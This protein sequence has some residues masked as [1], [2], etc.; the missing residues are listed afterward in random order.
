MA[1]F[2]SKSEVF[3]TQSIFRL[4][5]DALSKPGRLV[6]VPAEFLQKDEEPWPYEEASPS[7]H[8]LFAKLAAV[9]LDPQV[10]FYAQEG[11]A[12]DLALHTQAQLTSAEEADYLFITKELAQGDLMELVAQA[13]AGTLFDPQ[14]AAL[15]FCEVKR[16]E[17]G[18]E[19][20][21]FALSGPGIKD[22]NYLK[23]S[24][25]QLFEYRAARADEFPLGIDL[26]LFD[27]A[28]NLVGIPR[29]TLV[30]E[31]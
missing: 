14:Q 31:L 20:D 1:N 10:S 13:K 4:M 16:L 25:P 12:Q 24:H 7:Y 18:F 23:L 11:M 29:T 19:Q 3:E 9:V 21:G 5:L 30:K 6:K 22:R 17:Q 27:E 8:P 2:K 15:L 26:V 28:S